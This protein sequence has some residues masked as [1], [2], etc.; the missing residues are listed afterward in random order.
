MPEVVFTLLAIKDTHDVLVITAVF[1][2][3]FF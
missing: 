1:K 3:V 2:L